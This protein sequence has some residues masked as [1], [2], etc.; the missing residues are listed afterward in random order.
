MTFHVVVTENAKANL[1]HYYERAAENAPL[2]AGRWLNRFED[3]LK[4]LATNPERCSVAPENNAVEPEIRQL[5]FGK[6]NGA[7]RALFTIVGSEVQVLHIRRAAM[8]VATPDE[9]FE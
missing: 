7:Y 1:R 2:T 9:L 8:N 6:R 3:A 4:T 5:T